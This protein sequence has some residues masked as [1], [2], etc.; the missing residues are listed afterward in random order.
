MGGYSIKLTD[1][2]TLS[3]V[4]SA[5]GVELGPVRVHVKPFLP[6]KVDLLMGTDMIWVGD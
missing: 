2:V 4:M 3:S 6:L 5:G 1:V